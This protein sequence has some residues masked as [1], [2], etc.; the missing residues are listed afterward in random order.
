MVSSA[1]IVFT[2]LGLGWLLYGKRQRKT[3]RRS[4]VLEVAQPVV[5]TV[6][7]KQIFR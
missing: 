6:L 7:R 1:V 4:D 5:F 2:G 3:V